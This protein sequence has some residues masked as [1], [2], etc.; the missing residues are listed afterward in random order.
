MEGSQS[1]GGA[2]AVHIFMKDK[3][4]GGGVVPKKQA[5]LANWRQLHALRL[6]DGLCTSN[7]R[8]HKRFALE[9]LP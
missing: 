9:A 6:Q 5:Q 1:K 2:E 8:T 3:G 4:K 7:L